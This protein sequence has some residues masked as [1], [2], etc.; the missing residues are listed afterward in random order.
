VTTYTRTQVAIILLNDAKDLYTKG[1][2][3][4]SIVLAGAAQQLLRDLCRNVKIDPTIK[5][6]SN[7]QNIHGQ[8]LHDLIAE[9]YNKLKHADKE[10]GDVEVDKDEAKILLV[11]AASDLMRLNYPQND[12]IKNFLK[13]ADTLSCCVS[14]ID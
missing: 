7:I 9:T 12:I 14:S 10:Q 5:I 3:I 13:F 4:S 8:G 2:F 1:K 11:L 6:L